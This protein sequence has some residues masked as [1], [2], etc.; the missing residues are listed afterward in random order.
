M[1][2]T[3]ITTSLSST[4]SR[5]TPW[6][7]FVVCLAQAVLCTCDMSSLRFGTFS[8][9]DR[10]MNGGPLANPPRLLAALSSLPETLRETIDDKADAN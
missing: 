2:Y 10:V 6:R 7:H 1:K 9:V 5:T 8:L 4:L 3:R